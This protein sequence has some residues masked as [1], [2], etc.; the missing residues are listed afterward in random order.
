MLSPFSPSDIVV[1]LIQG[2]CA[3]SLTGVVAAQTLYYF[4]RYPDDRSSIKVTVSRS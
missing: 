3:F 2:G 1:A 4:Q